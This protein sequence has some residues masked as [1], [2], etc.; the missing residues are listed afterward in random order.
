MCSHGAACHAEALAKE[1]APCA[2]GPQGRGYNAAP[3]L[4]CS[5]TPFDQSFAT[6]PP[7]ER[8]FAFVPA[9]SASLM[10]PLRL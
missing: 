4:H 1:G 5:I 6:F 7:H 10:S 2:H 3:L 8:I 9:A